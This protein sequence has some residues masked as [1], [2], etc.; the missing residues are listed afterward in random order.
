[1]KHTTIRMLPVALAA[2][3]ILA[4]LTTPAIAQ[5]AGAIPELYRQ[6]YAAEAKQDYDAAQGLMQ[7]IHAAGVD[8][9]VSRLRSA[10]LFYLASNYPDAIVEY[11]RAIELEPQAVEPRLGLMLPLMAARKW[12]DARVVGAEVLERAPGDFAAQSRMAY[13]HYQMGQYEKAESWYRK[14]LA[15]HPSNVEMRAG[16]GWSLLRQNRFPEARV[17]FAKVLTIAP[18]HASSREGIAQLP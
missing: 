16:L 17:E 6:S 4:G 14:A 3:A 7:R 8:D 11:R 5:Q 10:W 12:T 18:D 2:A 15:G 1:M 13:I 9:Y